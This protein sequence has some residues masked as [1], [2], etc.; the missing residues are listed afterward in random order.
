M[1]ERKMRTPAMS[2]GLSGLDKYVKVFPKLKHS[3]PHSLG[4]ILHQN[5]ELHYSIWQTLVTWRYVM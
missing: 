4:K 2:T 3:G 5:V 1:K